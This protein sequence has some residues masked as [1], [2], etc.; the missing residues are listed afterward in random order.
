MVDKKTHMSEK[1]YR[2]QQ[3]QSCT[4]GTD[5]FKVNTIGTV[6]V[7]KPKFIGTGRL[8]KEH[9]DSHKEYD[10]QPM[11]LGAVKQL[12]RNFLYFQLASF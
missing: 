1:D 9:G 6:A 10:L 2:D 12:T 3:I 5:L 11:T 7:I 8:V 4:L